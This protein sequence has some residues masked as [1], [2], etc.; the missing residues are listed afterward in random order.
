MLELADVKLKLAPWP[1]VLA[2]SLIISLLF[3]PTSAKV[4][5]SLN[6]IIVPSG[7]PPFPP[8]RTMSDA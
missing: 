3:N 2:K 5:A 8:F 7:F 4:S 1:V 6:A